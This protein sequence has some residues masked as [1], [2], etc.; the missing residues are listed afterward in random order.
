MSQ[1]D[2]L[3][4]G[5]KEGLSMIKPSAEEAKRVRELYGVGLREAVRMVKADNMRTLLRQ[6]PFVISEIDAV[7]AC[8]WT[9]LDDLYGPDK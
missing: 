2:H 6:E 7:K 4:L 5:I 9:I 3:D 8:I 1:Y